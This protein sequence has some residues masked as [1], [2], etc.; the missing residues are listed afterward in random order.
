MDLDLYGVCV[1][2][3]PWR[4]N[5]KMLSLFCEDGN[6]YDVLARGALKPKYKLKFAAQLFSTGD[7]FLCPSKAGYYILGGASFGELSFLGAASDP[8][9]Y[10][11]ACYVCEIAY[12]CVKTENKIMY[13]EVLSS[14]SELS[15]GSEKLRPTLV[16]L[17]TVLVAL[18]SCGYGEKFD[19]GEVGRACTS[20][21]NTEAGNASGAEVDDALALRLLKSYTVRFGGIFERVASLDTLVGML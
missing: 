10:A 13:A 6:V 17:K 5:D 2:V 7:Y 20:V 8:V 1:R 21:I 12:K 15:G 9:A 14:L 18:S 4:E 19:G 3:R 11:A 16:C